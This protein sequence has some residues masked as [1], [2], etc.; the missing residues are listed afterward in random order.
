M[1]YV[2]KATGEREP[3]SQ[4]KLIQSARRAG[5]P[6]AL[7]G[8]LLQVVNAHVYNDIHTS[9]IYKDILN[10][11]S[12]KA[13]HIKARYSLKQAIMD[14]G[15]TGFPFEDYIAR[16]LDALGYET[17]TRQIIRGKCISHEI[18]V[19]ASKQG[20]DP[21]K[22]MVEAKFHNSIG[23]KTEVH[24]SMYTQARF[25]D[26]REKEKFDEVW[27]VTNT[28]A[29]TDAI[30]YAGCAG[31]KIISWE[32]PEEESLRELIERYALHP[33][34]ALTTLSQMEKQML[35]QE[36]VV[37]CTD[38]YHDDNKL[39]SIN[40]ADE[41]RKKILTEARN[42]IGITQKNTPITNIS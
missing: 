39:S 22:I 33:I 35:L 14:L 23:V 12:K 8:E 28:K 34:T 24:V 41:R 1:L 37:L 4:E 2:I 9:E 31:M 3:F 15:P 6:E 18:D 27:L 25:D 42:I 16:L 19:I 21:R 30:A 38:L 29:T 10:F 32:Y 20:I 11:L 26:I 17:M 5:V 7:E 13:P 40:M 36:G